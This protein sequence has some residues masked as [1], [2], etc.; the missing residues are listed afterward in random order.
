M[1]YKRGPVFY[2]DRIPPGYPRRIGPLSTRTR[3]R[4]LADQ[5][6]ATVLELA[7]S[8]RHDLLDSLRA[9]KFSLPDLHSSKARGALAPLLKEAQDP[10]L[11]TVIAEFRSGI[12]DPRYL[13]AIDRLLDLAPENARQ[14]WLGDPDNIR[15]L[16]R[17]YRNLGLTAATERREMA[18]IS[19][20]V[21]ECL[22]ESRRREI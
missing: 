1:A 9:G 13:P 16:V 8:G 10:M 14:S 6:E 7:S 17:V 22:G 21:R 2:V 5:M 19:K 12:N 15:K 18:G 3:R 11:R 4:A 20:L